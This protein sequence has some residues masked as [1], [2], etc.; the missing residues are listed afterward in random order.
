MVSTNSKKLWLKIWSLK[1]HGK[2]YK[3]IFYKKHNS[4]FKWLHDDFGSNF[5]MTEI[6]A[7]IGRK[8]LET[9]DRQIKKRNFIASIYLDELKDYYQKYHFLN[10]PDYKCNSCPLKNVK[11]ECNKCT[12]SFYRLNLFIN[13]N[14][15]KQDELI[16][17]FH[18]HKINCGVGSCPEIY[19]EKI[20]NKLKLYPKKRL[21][22]AKLL[23]ETSV[24]FPINPYRS[25]SKIKS[26]I[27]IIKKNF[28]SIYFINVQK[29][30]K[31]RLLDVVISIVLI[32]IFFPSYVANIF[33]I[34]NFNWI[35]NFFTIKT[36][37]Q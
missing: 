29:L 5:R 11:K 25:L 19:R 18:D 20:F 6:Q 35:S 17:K 16:K 13:K 34:I 8:Q 28:F 1:D 9:L 36:R 2:N 21:P 26:E 22:N 27:K 14:I 33:N 30:S 12:H 10:I 32:I 37:L 31:K 4:G 15:I 24:M 7:A 23:G 3:S